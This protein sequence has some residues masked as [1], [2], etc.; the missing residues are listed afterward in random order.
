METKIE[1]TII[2]T[3]P[4]TFDI[5]DIKSCLSQL[6]YDINY[7]FGEITGFNDFDVEIDYS[8]HGTFIDK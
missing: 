6:E 7:S 4:R 8:Q 1:V 2:I 5:E 3:P